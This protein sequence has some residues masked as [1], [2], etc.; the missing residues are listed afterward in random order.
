MQN[1]ENPKVIYHDPICGRALAGAAAAHPSTEYKKR[2]YFF[3]SEG[4]RKAFSHRAEKLRLVELARLGA[5]MGPG[6]VRWGMA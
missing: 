3:C 1:A 4:C 2:R 5:L 6:H